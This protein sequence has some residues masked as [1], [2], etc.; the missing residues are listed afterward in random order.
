MQARHSDGWAR[1]SWVARRQSQDAAFP[2]KA[3]R[4]AGYELP[5]A[6]AVRRRR[7]NQ[8]GDGP[9]GSEDMGKTVGMG[10]YIGVD[11]LTG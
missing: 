2:I 9:N 3:K 1:V 11:E 5:S 7:Q 10:P 8:I 6:L 4:V